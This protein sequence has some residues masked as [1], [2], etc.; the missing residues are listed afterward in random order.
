M[1]DRK[2]WIETFIEH[3]AAER[4]LSPHTCSNYCRD[5]NKLERHLQHLGI[6]GWD[7]VDARQ[8]RRFIALQHQQ[9]LGGRSLM[10]LLSSIRTFYHYLLREGQVADNPA[11]GISAPKAPSRLPKTLDVDQVN[12]LLQIDD[13]DPLACRDLAMMELFYSSGLRLAELV[14]LDLNAIDLRDGSLRVTGKGRK[15]REVPVGRVAIEAIEAW[16]GLRDGLASPEER[17]L[18]V[19]SRGSRISPRTIQLRLKQWGERQGVRGGLHPHRLRHSFASHM[20]ESSG[21][22]RAVQ[23]MLGHADISTTQIYTHLDFRHLAEVYDGAHPRA[24]KGS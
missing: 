17:A 8:M 9:G 6:E 3:L 20:L 13:E 4:R 7:A 19:S 22:L 14:S 12:G 5:L 2:A 16:L 10:R 1:S 23:E 15:I 18:F 11:L 21:D 24:K